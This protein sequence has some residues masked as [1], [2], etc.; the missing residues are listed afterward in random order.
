MMLFSHQIATSAKRDMRTRATMGAITLGVVVL[1][2]FGGVARAEN[3]CGAPEPGVEIVCSPSNYDPSDGNIFYGPDESN[4]DFTIRLTDDLV[5]DYD[6]EAPGDDFYSL[7]GDP[8]SRFYSAI[9]ITPA[10]MGYGYKGDISVVSSADVTSNGRGI[11]VGHYGESGALRMELTG[12]HFTTTGDRAHG[13]LGGHW[14]AGDVTINAQDLTVSTTGE[15]GAGI[16]GQHVG[17]GSLDLHVQGGAI[18]TTGDRA[19]GIFGGHSGTGDVTI[20]AQDLTVSTTGDRAYGIFGGH[21]DAGD[22]TI[23]AQDLTVS[24]TGDRA[25]GIFGGHFDAGD[26]TINAQDLTVSAVGENADGIGGQHTGQGSLNIHVQGGAISTTGENAYGI[27]GGHSGTGDSSIIARNIT[28]NTNGLMYANAIFSSHLGTGDIDIDVGNATFMVTGDNSDGIYASHRGE[29]D[30]NVD[31]QGLT[32]AANGTESNGVYGD[33]RGAE[34][35]VHIDVRGS[36]ITTRG[37]NSYG[38]YA[39]HESGI[40]E[41]RITVDGGTI[42]AAGMDASGIQIGRLNEEGMVERA[43]AL[44]E[45]GYRNQSV[46]VNGQVFGGSGEAAGVYLAGGGRVMIGLQGSLG[47]ESGVAIRATGDTLDSA[48]VTRKPKLYLDANLAGRRM[49]SVIQGD[50]QNDGGETTIVVNGVKLYDDAA[51]ATGLEVLNGAWDVTLRGR[52]PIA[53]RAFSAN[54][55]VE[56][57]APRAAVYEALPGLLLRL[58]SRGPAG[59]RLTAPGSPAWVRVAGGAGRYAATQAS[60]GAKYDFHRVEV[61]AGLDVALGKRLTGSLSVRHVQG[62]GDVS[63]PTGGG[64][65]NARGLGGAIGVAWTG[66][67]GYYFQGRLSVIDY[68]VDLVSDTRGTLT[69]DAS[70]LGHSLGFETGRRFT[71]SE[72]ITL[73]P[74]VWVTRSKISLDFTDA[75]QSRLSTED[76]DRLAAGTGLVAETE[77]VWDD[78]SKAFAVRGALDL[79]KTLGDGTALK[80]SQGEPLKSV[81]DKTRVLVS[82]GAAYRCGRFSVRSEVA[83]GGLGSR[84]QEYAGYLNLGIQF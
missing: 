83:A 44:G 81:S 29:G 77:H 45:D 17:Q 1:L 14:G 48:G 23:N 56:V 76:S 54:D 67:R 75:V 43:A 2:A 65:I 11:S 51:G 16:F 57:Y 24:T 8:E 69:E 80:V 25:N 58:N 46:T 3:E 22:V 36:R 84:D 5:L 31:A 78:G 6:R 72:W 32:I 40:G 66:P 15:G 68:D 27:F 12:G 63:S 62:S 19:Y 4:G 79:W 50:V 34:G 73:T 9:W 37:V 30:I 49:A 42:R 70:A 60:V 7:P 39:E 74:R 21:F 28:V 33:H 55:V 53:D 20:N 41:V 18:S 38:I 82:L 10:E 26:V 61:E 64:E 59:E 47:A 13:I 52:E 71:L 35:D